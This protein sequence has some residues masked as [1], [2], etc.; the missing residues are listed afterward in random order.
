MAETI[1]AADGECTVEMTN[2]LQALAALDKIE[3]KEKASII[4]AVTAL[5]GQEIEMAN[6][7][8]IQT[9]GG[10]QIFWAVESTNCCARIMKSCAP[11]CAPWSVEIMYTQGGANEKAFTLNRPCTLTCC[12]F[13][14]PSMELTDASGKTLGYMTDP[15]AMCDLTFTVK[16]PSG[17]PVV[18]ASGGCCQWGLCC[19][20]PCGPCAEVNFGLTDAKSGAE[21]G[22]VQKKVPGCCKFFLAPDVDNYKIDFGKITNPQYKALVMCLSMF[23]DFRYFNDNKNDDDKGGGDS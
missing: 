23:I 4:E 15:C 7:Y 5:L 1:G 2:S 22:N 10:E 9:E 20:L 6:K 16:D 21:L 13:N 12:C 3:V 19:P 17:E 11:D 18:K 14:R 8:S